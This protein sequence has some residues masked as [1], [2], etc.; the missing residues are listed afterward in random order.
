MITRSL[1]ELYAFST[2]ALTK[3]R[4]NSVIVEIAEIHLTFRDNVDEQFEILNIK[5]RPLR[6]SVLFLL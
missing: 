1:P 5:N 4:G 3:P 2:K 6:G